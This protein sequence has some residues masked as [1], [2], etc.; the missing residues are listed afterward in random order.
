M[1]QITLAKVRNTLRDLAPTVEI[2]LDVASK[3]RVAIDRM[4]AVRA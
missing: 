4:L 3:A 2:P 1:K